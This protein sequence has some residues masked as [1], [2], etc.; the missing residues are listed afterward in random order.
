MPLRARHGSP[1]PDG[2]GGEGRALVWARLLVAA[3]QVV[4]IAYQIWDM[5]SHHQ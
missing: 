1:E 2:G 4:L 5:V 3:L